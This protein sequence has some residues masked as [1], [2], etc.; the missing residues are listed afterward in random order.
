MSSED[1]EAQE[2]ELLALTSI[3]SE[4]EFKRADN[5]PGG[6]FQVCL[7]LPPN[8]KV[9][10]KS[11]SA[12]NAVTENFED[13]VFFLPPII[14]NFE[15]PSGYPSSTPPIFTLSCKW[16][17]PKQLSLLCQR[18]DDLW[19]EN[20]GCVVL[21]AW[22]QFLKEGTIEYL[23]IKSP[24]EIDVESNGMQIWMQTSEEGSPC[25]TTE[26]PE[27]GAVD[28][29]AI[30]DVESVAALIR[31]ILDFNEMQQ[32][33]CFE[34]KPFLCNICFCEKLGSE[35]TYFMQCSHVY[36]NSCL[37][38]YFKIQIKDGQ[39]HSLNC[40]EIKCT[41][42]ATPAQVK[43]LVGDELFS[44]YDRLLL[45]SSLDLMTDVVYCP[46]P[47][48]QTPVIKEPGGTMGICSGCQYAFCCR[49][50]MAFH[51]VS[52]CKMIG[53]T[54]QEAPLASDVTAEARTYNHNKSK[55]WEDAY[56]GFEWWRWEDLI[57]L[58]DDYWGADKE[59]KKFLEKKFG[60]KAILKVTE[61]IPNKEWL[62]GN[63]KSCPS[64]GA[65]IQKTE[66][67]NRMMCIMCNNYFCWQC[68]SILSGEHC[69][70]S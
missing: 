57:K 69:C 62:Q 20:K 18:L 53:A 33:K 61:D 5:V 42:V 21:F 6:K 4:D 49:C 17:S 26:T 41:S 10:V 44:R 12:T 15:L 66:G 24:Y 56:W 28:R 43:E 9:S 38:D 11:T 54:A 59:G 13:T 52:P 36:C 68:L 50:L 40:P 67:C 60:K 46:R 27:E 19:E 7:E 58:R 3:Y 47:S 34:S 32:K 70:Y 55:L 64:C 16:L 39:V 25:S 22:M 8:F 37:R 35:C 51:G 31:H 30:Q 29:R 14:L 23:N 2:D 63:S 45:Q 1:Q 65:N 48:C